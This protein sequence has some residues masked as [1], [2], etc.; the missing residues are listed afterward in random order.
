MHPL[1]LILHLMAKNDMSLNYWRLIVQ[2]R[3]HHIILEN[4][5]NWRL[6]V[7]VCDHHIKY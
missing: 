1:Y 2:V 6:I 3:D 5:Y 4:S 7:Q